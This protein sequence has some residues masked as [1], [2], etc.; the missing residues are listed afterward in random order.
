MVEKTLVLVKPD[1]VQRGLTGEIINRF[2]RKGLRLVALKMLRFDRALSR[3]HYAD[4]VEKDFYPPLEDFIVSGPCV[5]MI[6]EGPDAIALV[7]LMMG[8]T[9]HLGAQAG[10][11]RGDFSTSNRLN[12]VHGSD[13]PESAAREI[14]I[15]FKNE[16]IYPNA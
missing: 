6:I 7:R 15:F 11:I 9:S 16:E 5:A 8:A 1:G 3:R 10:T 14:G 12:L 13:C 2:E 4:H